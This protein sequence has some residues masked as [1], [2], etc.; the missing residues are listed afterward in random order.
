MD[1]L[2]IVL[3]WITWI[4]R[5]YGVLSIAGFALVFWVFALVRG[6]TRRY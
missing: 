2:Q 5:H 1:Y 6:A 4:V 3:D